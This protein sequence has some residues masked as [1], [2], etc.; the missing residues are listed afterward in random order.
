MRYVPALVP[1]LALLALCACTT[2]MVSEV[3]RPGVDDDADAGPPVTATASGDAAQA[4]ARDP[5][6]GPWDI[7]LEDAGA[8]TAKPS[9]D[10]GR[11]TWRPPPEEIVDADT[12][13]G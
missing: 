3:G 10:A 1:T 4:D 2:V 12:D 7:P 13:S 6:A 9:V 11:D 5:N 8:D